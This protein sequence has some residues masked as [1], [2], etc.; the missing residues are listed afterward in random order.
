MVIWLSK[1]K[2]ELEERNRKLREEHNRKMMELVGVTI[3]KVEPYDHH[4]DYK[5]SLS[6]TSG[7]LLQLSNGQVL[8][9]NDGE[10]GDDAFSFINS[11]VCGNW[12]RCDEKCGLDHNHCRTYPTD[13]NC[14]DWKMEVTDVEG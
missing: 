2:R 13:T 6:G 12:S 8:T 7:F 1:E 10:Y 11:K 14:P 5:H 4:Q 3:T 9:A